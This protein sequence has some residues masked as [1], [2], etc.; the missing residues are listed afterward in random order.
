MMHCTRDDASTIETNKTVFAP[1]MPGGSAQGGNGGLLVQWLHAACVLHDAV[2]VDIRAYL[3]ECP[4][5]DRRGEEEDRVGA[6]EALAAL[7][8]TRP[9]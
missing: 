8:R 4:R 9:R 7:V 6:A 1:A 2:G 3:T 5:Y